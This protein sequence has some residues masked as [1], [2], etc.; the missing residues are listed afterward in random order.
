MSH[1]SR[2]FGKTFIVI[3]GGSIWTNKSGLV[4]NIPT[5]DT[6]P[7][8][9][10]VCSSN[11]WIFLLPCPIIRCISRWESFFVR[12]STFV[13][14]YITFRQLTSTL[15]VWRNMARLAAYCLPCVISSFLVTRGLHINKRPKPF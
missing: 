3:A 8:S 6:W 7:S 13:T 4:P 11:F 15:T 2:F 5:H 1:R 10:I 14:A 12:F 9:R